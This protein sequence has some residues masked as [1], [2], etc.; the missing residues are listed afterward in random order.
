MAG[1]DC[2]ANGEERHVEAGS[3]AGADV[4]ADVG[5]RGRDSKG[6]RAS[7]ED[8]AQQQLYDWLGLE[9]TQEL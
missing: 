3:G 2:A 1:S 4:E 9:E 7:H 6:E 8:T 5:A